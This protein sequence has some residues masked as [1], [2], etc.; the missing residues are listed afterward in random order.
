MPYPQALE[1]ACARRIRPIMMTATATLAGVLPLALQPGAGA[2]I[3]RPLAIAVLGGIGLS[4][5]VVLVALPA[6]AVGL[7]RIG[8]KNAA[9]PSP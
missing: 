8:K 4:K 7:E 3:Q 5:F 1:L 6:I 9:Q 2:E